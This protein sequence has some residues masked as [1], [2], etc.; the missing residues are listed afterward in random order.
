MG[1][2]LLHLKLEAMRA[3]YGARPLGPGL[4]ALVRKH[5]LNR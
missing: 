5:A 4:F 1:S 2:P 3:Q